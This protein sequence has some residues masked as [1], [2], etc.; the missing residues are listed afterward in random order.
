MLDRINKLIDPHQSFSTASNKS[1]LATLFDPH[2]PQNLPRDF[3]KNPP[4]QDGCSEQH[5]AA[6][7]RGAARRKSNHAGASAGA[8]SRGEK[9]TSPRNSSS[10]GLGFGREQLL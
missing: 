2:W 6:S 7:P 5:P 9:T 1:R 4:L 10:G 8:P 3:R